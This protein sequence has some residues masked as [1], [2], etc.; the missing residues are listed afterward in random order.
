MELFWVS[1]KRLLSVR[2]NWDVGES[3]FENFKSK[4]NSQNNF[5]RCMQSWKP[6]TPGHTVAKKPLQARHNTVEF[7]SRHDIG[8]HNAL[9][10]M[11][12]SMVVVKIN[13]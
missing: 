9:K 6:L 11:K 5:T 8:G 3:D 10:L 2:V 7:T 1:V 4:T 13:H 12:W